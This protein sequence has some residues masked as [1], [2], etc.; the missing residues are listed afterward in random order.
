MFTWD[1]FAQVSDTCGTSVAKREVVSR[2]KKEQ[3]RQRKFA[4]KANFGFLCRRGWREAYKWSKFSKKWGKK[5]G[6][7]FWGVSAPLN[8]AGVRD[9]RVLAVFVYRVRPAH[10]ALNRRFLSISIERDRVCLG[11]VNPSCSFS[12]FSEIRQR[13]TEFDFR[14]E[15]SRFQIENK[16]DPSLPD[17]GFWDFSAEVA[18][19]V[20]FRQTRPL[21][22]AGTPKAAFS[23]R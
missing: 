22:A 3:A 17:F 1:S 15:N 13:G 14:S 6:P 18:S 21:S 4:F 7:I 20:N 5:L 19:R 2:T 16:L 23:A 10:S 12:E 11:P 9:F 8:S